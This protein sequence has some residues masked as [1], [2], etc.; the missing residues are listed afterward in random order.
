MF[1]DA[2]IAC[3]AQCRQWHATP[4]MLGEVLVVAFDVLEVKAKTIPLG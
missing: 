4:L 3:V 2:L 1:R